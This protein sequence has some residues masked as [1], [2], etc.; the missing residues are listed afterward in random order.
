LKDKQMM[1][2][3]I[4]LISGSA[5]PGIFAR[6]RIVRTRVTGRNRFRV[7]EELPE[8]HVSIRSTHHLA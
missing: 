8:Q 3:N 4:A 2:K 1:G 7:P 6:P 5:T